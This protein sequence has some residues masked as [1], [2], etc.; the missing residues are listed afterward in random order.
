MKRLETCPINRVVICIAGAFQRIG[1]TNAMTRLHHGL[2][3]ELAEPGTQ[4]VFYPWFGNWSDVARWIKQIEESNDRQQ[5]VIDLVGYSW[6]GASAI[7]LAWEL[8]DCGLKVR[9]IL[10]ADAVYRHRYRAG[11]WRAFWPHSKLVVPSTV[12]EVFWVRQRNPRFR[13]FHTH[14]WFQPAGHDVVPESADSLGPAIHEPV[15]VDCVHNFVDDSAE[16]RAMVVREL[17]DPPPTDP[18]PNLSAA[19]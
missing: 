5:P 13:P 6:G 18:S 4:V 1:Q 14:G 12:G 2:H 16:F 10:L 3:C 17:L 19:A 8:K 7:E 15:I 11:N 9:K